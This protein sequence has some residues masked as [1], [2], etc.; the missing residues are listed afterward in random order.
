LL[1]TSYCS[2]IYSAESDSKC[3]G[4]E[5]GEGVQ[6]LWVGEGSPPCV[7]LHRLHLS[8]GSALLSFTIALLAI[9]T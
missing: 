1:M 9:V 4:G 7:V 2:S 6:L 8:S 5:H 3:G